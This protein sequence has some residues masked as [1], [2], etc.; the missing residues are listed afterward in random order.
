[1]ALK[2]RLRRIGKRPKKRPFFRI[3]VAESSWARDGKFIE[4]IG[5]YDPTK[6]PPLIKLN[7]ER[8]QYWIKKGAKP[9]ETVANLA[10]K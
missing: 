5:F 3:T 8:Y 7:K 4:E 9:T 6:N 1:M 2:I 10:K